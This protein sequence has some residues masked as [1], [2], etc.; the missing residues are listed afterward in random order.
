MER[1][2]RCPECNRQFERE[3]ALEEHVTTEHGG[4]GLKR[5]QEDD[6]AS[7]MEFPSDESI[8]EHRRSRHPPEKS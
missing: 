6:P 4:L 1:T 2:L 7:T 8:K 3:R 5:P